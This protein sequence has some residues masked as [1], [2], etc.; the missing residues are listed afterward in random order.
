MIIYPSKARLHSLDTT[1]GI[2]I[3][4]VDSKFVLDSKALSKLSSVDISTAIS[5]K[6]GG[7]YI[8]VHKYADKVAVIVSSE[9]ISKGW[10]EY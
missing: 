1:N 10:W 3:D 2:V 7:L 5:Y 4:F 8:D 6:A 9:P